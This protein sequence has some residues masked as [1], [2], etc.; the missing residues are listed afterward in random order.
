MPALSC[1]LTPNFIFN[2]FIIRIFPYNAQYYPNLFLLSIS[3]IHEETG[4]RGSRIY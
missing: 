4:L 3:P 1:A 2:L